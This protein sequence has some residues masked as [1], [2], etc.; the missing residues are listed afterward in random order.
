MSVSLLETTVKGDSFGFSTGSNESR[1][2]EAVRSFT[3]TVSGGGDYITECLAVLP[4]KGDV[5]PYYPNT[6]VESIDCVAHDSDPYVYLATVTYRT[7]NLT[8]AG[9]AGG[10]GETTED[11]PEYP[12][13][14]PAVL[15]IRTNASIMQVNELAYAQG[16]SFVQAA[17]AFNEDGSLA[18]DIEADTS[19][20]YRIANSLGERPESLPEE[21]ETTLQLNVT[22]AVEWTVLSDLD[23]FIE[24]HGTVNNN[25]VSIGKTFLPYTCYM[26]DISATPEVYEYTFAGEETASEFP[27]WNVTLTIEYK[28][29]TWFRLVVNESFN[30]LIDES[31][32]KRIVHIAAKEPSSS[33]TTGAAGTWAKIT[34]PT[35]IDADGQPLD[36]DATGNKV[37]P[38]LGNDLS[39]VRAYLTK[40][41]ADWT[42]ALTSII[43][44]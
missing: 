10:G 22:F 36:F 19:P 38:L 42:T 31:G 14:Q 28:K 44:L 5:H 7:R 40:K 20:V 39:F 6:Y 13:E 15:S 18:G 1:T 23:P 24:L 29:S 27:Y 32:T 4:Q 16:A 12:W 35:R 25:F 26:S 8:D 37:S 30:K 3:I 11:N 17:L 21:P 41:P 33:S 2:N 34:Q 43:G 9:T